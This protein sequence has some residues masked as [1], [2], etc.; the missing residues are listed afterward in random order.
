MVT[1]ATCS[2]RWNR[3]LV[4]LLGHFDVNDALTISA[5]AKYVRSQGF[6]IAQP[7]YDFYLLMTP[8]N[9]YM[10]DVIRDAIVPGAAQAFLGDDLVAPKGALITRD[11]YDL[12]VNGEDTT[13]ETL[14]GVLAASGNL[15]DRL[16][17]EASYVYG[18]TKSKIVSVNNRITDRWLAAIDVVED[19][20][21]QPVCRSSLDPDADESLAGCVPYNIFGDGV[22]D[23]DAPDF[24]NVDSVSHSKVTQQVASGSVSGDFGSFLEMPGGAIGFAAGAEY[25]RETSDSMP[26]LEIQDGSSWNGPITPSEGSFDVKEIF[27]ELNV[28]V[29]KD[30]RFAERLS[31]GAAVRAS[32]YS[33]VG[34]TSSW[35]FDTV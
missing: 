22:R 23:E 3:H 29:L 8:D 7:T 4:N 5:E 18:E 16:R 28:P 13:R 19:G 6:S 20:N 10:P 14:R 2:P 32:D 9:P 31:F 30:A 24:V 35:K 34:T 21:G 11:N 1:R 26:A 12:G 33:T 27:A 25:R 15:S 17:Y